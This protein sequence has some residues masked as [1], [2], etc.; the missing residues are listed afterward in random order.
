MKPGSSSMHRYAAHAKD[1]VIGAHY[2]RRQAVAPDVNT[3][4]LVFFRSLEVE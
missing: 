1:A 2:S 4:A 3:G